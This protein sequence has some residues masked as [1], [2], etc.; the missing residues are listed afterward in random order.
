MT[1]LLKLLVSALA[2]MAC[3]VSP[4]YAGQVFDDAAA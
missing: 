4:A 2:T 3:T 1:S